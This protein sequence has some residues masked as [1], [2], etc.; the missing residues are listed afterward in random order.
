MNRTRRYVWRA[1]VVLSLLSLALLVAS[2][3][4]SPTRN[5][6]PKRTADRGGIYSAGTFSFG[7]PV[8][9]PK[10]NLSQVFFQQDAEPEIKTDSFGNIYQTAINGVPGGTDLWKSTDKGATFVNLG[11]PDGAQDHCTMLPQCAAA[12]GGDDSI[13]VSNGGYLYVSSLWLG[14]VTMSTSTDGGTG[15]ALP[16]QA[17][18][19]NPLAATIPGDDRQWIAAYGPQTVYMSYTDI[20]TGAVRVEK[21]VDAG[22]TFSLPVS[23]TTSPMSDLQGNMAVDQYNGNVYVVFIP[24]GAHNQIY[25]G[26]ST[27]GGSTFTTIKAYEGPA[28]SDNGQ[29]FPSMALDRVGNIH[30]VFSRCSIPGHTNCQIYLVSSADQGTTWNDAVRVSDLSAA[31]ATAVEPSV[32]AGGDGVVNVTWLGSPAATP[33]VASNWHVFF[34]QTWNALSLTP[35]FAQNQAESAVMHDQ[36]ICFNGLGCA[37]TPNQSPGNRDLLEYFSMTID[38]DGNANIAYTDTVTNCNPTTCIS[39]SWFTKQTGGPSAFAPPPSPGPATFA[40]NVLLPQKGEGE[41]SIWVDTHNCIYVTAPGAPSVWKSENGGTTFS[42]PV[43]PV[44]DESTLTGGDED[45]ITVPKAGGAK[46]D[47]VYF[48]DLGLSTVH[49]RKS[50]DGGAAWAKPGVGGI[51]GDTAVS[52][53]RQ[54]LAGDIVGADQNIYEWDHELVSEVMRVSSSTNDS[55]WVTVSGMSDPELTTTVPNTNPGPIFVNK[56]THTVYGIFNASIPTTNA[57]NPPFGKLLNVWDAVG[58]GAP[59]GGGPAGPFTNHPVFKGVVDSPTTPPTPAGAVTHGTNNAN[60]FPAGDIDTAGNVY[61]AWSMNNARTNEFSIWFASSHDGGQNFYGP[62]QISQGPGTAVF[63][64]V[65]AGS[66]NR[67][68]V[69]W[70]QSTTVGDPNTMPG[71][72]AWNVMFG[73]SQNASTRQPVFTVSQASDHVIHYGP[74][75]T[76]G[77]IGSSDRTLLDF[78]EVAVDRSG[79]ANVAYADDHI[80]PGSARDYYAKQASGPLALSAPTNPTC[81]GGATAVT[82]ASFNARGQ[83]HTVRVVWRTASEL[84]TVGFNIWRRAGGSG[85]YTKL[86]ARLIP[87]KSLLGIGAN[88]YEYV[89]RLVRAGKTY[90]YRL[91]LVGSNGKSRWAGPVSARAKR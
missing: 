5:L 90:S 82:V 42:N 26:R 20:V 70:Y 12:G 56:T 85:S 69:V 34:A 63:P 55:A 74:I 30:I 48:A 59:S 44:A 72:A 89:D 3:A 50:V 51:A 47:P 24:V 6:G 73:Q 58:P 78:F 2:A 14:S 15:G 22:K 75:S 21:S 91:E 16:G 49:I 45:I 76:G 68:D 38:P 31:T 13:D 27:N 7:T 84:H 10:P 80:T 87:S 54:W 79:L 25:L 60:I 81:P 61:V 71:A 11:Q 8:Q 86:N 19:V 32:A 62:F 41:P 67:V 17:W 57:M 53:D 46:P 65:A 40:A 77:L 28:G 35:T 29:V 33:D 88:P 23:A 64:W 4:A 18:T 36:D 83:R 1:A 43:N 37:A 39:N 66:A 9:M 52:S